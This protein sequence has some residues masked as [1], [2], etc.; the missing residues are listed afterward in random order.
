MLVE[1]EVASARVS[2]TKRSMMKPMSPK[3]IMTP[4]MRR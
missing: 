3:A 1:G 2:G 4:R